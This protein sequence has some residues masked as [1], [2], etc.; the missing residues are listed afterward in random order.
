MIFAFFE[1]FVFKKNKFCFLKIIFF[2]LFIS[3][4]QVGFFSLFTFHFSLFTFH[5]SFFIFK[6]AAPNQ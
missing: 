2:A 1:F 6:A 3:T 4:V 5:F